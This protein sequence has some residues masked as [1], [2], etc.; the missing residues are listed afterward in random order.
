MPP[1]KIFH[2]P[3]RLSSIGL[4]AN[5][6][7]ISQPA[8]EHSIFEGRFWI[9][10]IVIL[11]VSARQT[12]YIRM[13]D[14]FLGRGQQ[15]RVEIESKQVFDDGSPG[16]R[17]GSLRSPVNRGRE[18]SVSKRSGIGMSVC[19]NVGRFYFSLLSFSLFTR[20]MWECI[21]GRYTPL[22][23]SDGSGLKLMQRVR[24]LKNDF[25]SWVDARAGGRV[26]PIGVATISREFLPRWSLSPV[27]HT[28]P[29][30]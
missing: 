7:E 3:L 15:G 9:R 5:F 10:S 29:Q 14:M 4:H 24:V 6:I 19:T 23:I 21:G 11:P 16:D 26:W 17:V 30:F 13:L 18:K 12:A 27:L 1:S 25:V 2:L 22:C 28:L 20:G 8:K